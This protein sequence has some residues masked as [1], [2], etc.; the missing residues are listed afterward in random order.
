ME[1]I[2]NIVLVDDHVVIRNG[3]KE[4]IEKIGSF[5]V[6]H[7][8]DNGR[9]FMDALPFKNEPDLIIM[10]ISMPDM[11]GDKVLEELKARQIKLPI[12]VLTLNEDEGLIINLFRMG[13]RGY[14]KKNCSSVILKE[15][16]SEILKNGYYHNEFLTL[17]LL[18]ESK[19]KKNHQE[20]ILEQLTIREREFLKLVCNEKEYTYEQIAD[21]MNVQ[22]RTV[23]GYRESIF[24]KFAI[25]SKTGL[26][27]FILK[28]KL[29]DLL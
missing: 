16:I 28:H 29:F 22:H 4:L 15:A 5:K 14:L 11:S 25:K 8:F 6:T 21:K 3:L 20:L 2:K 10:D 13:A 27:L 7:Q 18:N 19:S 1:S 9:S 23:D 12:L 24:D 17:S 26:V